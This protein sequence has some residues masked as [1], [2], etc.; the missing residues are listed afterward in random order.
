MNDNEKPDNDAEITDNDIRLLAL[1]CLLV[2]VGLLYFFNI[3]PAAAQG[4]GGPRM[5]GYERPEAYEAPPCNAR[6]NPE[7]GRFGW[8]GPR[9]RQWRYERHPMM[10]DAPRG[11]GYPYEGPRYQW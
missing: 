10:P 2:L 9:S 1:G 5:W 7:C 8:E 11:R 4:Y 6:Y 3:I